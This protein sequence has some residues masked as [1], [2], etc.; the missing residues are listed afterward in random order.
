ML[1]ERIV[2]TA[3]ESLA[4]NN[5]AVEVAK[6]AVEVAKTAVEKAEAAKAEAAATS[7]PTAVA[8][9]M[10]TLREAKKLEWN[11]EDD[12]TSLLANKER[13]EKF[14]N[15]WTRDLNFKKKKGEGGE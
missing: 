8:T 12:V 10:E 6:A 2:D 9:A 15:E 1:V 11:L 7:D 14:L 5:A 3:T 4:T 13:A